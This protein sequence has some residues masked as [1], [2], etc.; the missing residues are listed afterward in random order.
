MK[1][2]G[3][4]EC[5]FHRDEVLARGFPVWQAELHTLTLYPRGLPIDLTKTIC[6]QNLCGVA[7][8][9]TV[10]F[11]DTNHITASYAASLAPNIEANLQ[12]WANRADSPIR[13]LMAK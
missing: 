7:Q 2:N 4:V 1:R 3:E 12:E 8:N 9:G 11:S 10:H 13:K 5:T 6:P